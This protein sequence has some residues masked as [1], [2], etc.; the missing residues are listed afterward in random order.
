VLVPEN[1]FIEKTAAAFGRS[2]SNFA[3]TVDSW[4]R[5]HEK[6]AQGLQ[7]TE[8][9]RL[10]TFAF[11]RA[12]VPARAD[13]SVWLFRSPSRKRDAFDGIANE[14]LGHRLGLNLSRKPEVRLTFGFRA[15]HVSDPRRPTYR[16]VSWEHMSLWRWNGVTQPLPRTPA[17][18][19][20]LEELV[21]T[22]PEIGQIDRDVVR[23]KLQKR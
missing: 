9:E 10:A 20:G 3:K 4:V 22:S 11:M 2:I 21:A 19:L 7:P 8:E 15:G 13:G 1:K 5:F 23:L 17:G 18:L 16:D 14:W 12:K 6:R